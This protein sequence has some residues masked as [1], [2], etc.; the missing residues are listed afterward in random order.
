[1]TSEA[2]ERIREKRQA[3][4]YREARAARGTT[5]PGGFV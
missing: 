2:A 5:L 1:V 3:A 4:R